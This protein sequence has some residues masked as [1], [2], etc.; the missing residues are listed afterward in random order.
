MHSGFYKQ[1]PKLQTFVI[2]AWKSPRSFL[3]LGKGLAIRLQRKPLGMGRC[4]IL[5]KFGPSHQQHSFIHR[6][7]TG[8]GPGQLQKSSRAGGSSQHTPPLRTP[9]FPG[10]KPKRWVFS[11]AKR[12]E[13][14]DPCLL[15]L[16]GAGQ[17]A[18]SPSK[19]GARQRSTW[20]AFE[21][22]LRRPP[23]AHG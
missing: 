14:P 16:P 5:E 6:P 10:F 3:R 21:A 20:A 23:P 2:W 8:A 19:P 17:A 22:Q 1:A 9:I 13:G 4:K 7:T 12:S 15:S 18:R 11:P